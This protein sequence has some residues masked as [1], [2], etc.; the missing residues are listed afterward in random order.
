MTDQIGD[1]EFGGGGT[2]DGDDVEGGGGAVEAGVE[3]GA[4][5]AAD[6]V[7]PDGVAGAGGDGDA[8]ARFRRVGGAA[9]SEHGLE[10]DAVTESPDAREVGAMPQSTEF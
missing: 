2:A 5:T 3:G 10:A 9:K 4:E 8:E 7:A 1:G 6:A